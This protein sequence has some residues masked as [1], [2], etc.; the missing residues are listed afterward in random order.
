MQSNKAPPLP[1]RR[2]RT[3]DD[4]VMIFDRLRDVGVQ[5]TSDNDKTSPIERI[6]RAT[7][8]PSTSKR[9][10]F[11]HLHINVADEDEGFDLYD[12]LARYIDDVVELGGEKKRMEVSLMVDLPP[13]L[14][15]QLQRAHLFARVH[16]EC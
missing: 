11:S 6:T 1:P 10:L 5:E 16:D 12:G 14:H 4:S 9:T 3:T 8:H 7:S 2:T 13:L 15:I